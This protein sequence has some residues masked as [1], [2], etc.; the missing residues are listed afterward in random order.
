MKIKCIIVDDEPSSQDVLQTFIADVF[1]LDLIAVCNNALEAI[2]VLN[3]NPK[4]DLLFL[5]INMPKISGLTLYRSLQ[6]PPNVIFTTAYTQYAIDGFNLNAVD[7][8]LKPFSF[9]RFFTAVN[10]VLEKQT[11]DHT[12]T[13]LNHSIIIK[14]NKVL[15]NISPEAILYIEA[16]GDY[17]K[18][19]LKDKFIL[20]NSTFKS[21]LS[22][23]KQY[24][25]VR[26]HKSF[27]INLKH[28]NSI[29]GNTIMI[30]NHKVPIGQTYKT[31]F[32]KTVNKA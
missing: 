11:I 9:E 30:N 25:F 8:L 32:L 22:T 14:S 6:N 24:A 21:I 26:T 13:K 16:F 23:L 12:P 2:E 1:F 20:T 18:V 5:D 3:K 28:L 31:A 7:Y 15:H 29:S 4:I 17:V 10:K 27:A 19:H